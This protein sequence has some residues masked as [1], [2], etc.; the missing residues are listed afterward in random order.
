MPGLIHGDHDDP[1]DYIDEGF[2]DD[3]AMRE[4][5]VVKL[6]HADFRDGAFVD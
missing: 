3:D 5:K 6:M 2:L 4:G 1:A